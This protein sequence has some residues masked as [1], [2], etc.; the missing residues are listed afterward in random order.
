MN[1]DDHDEGMHTEGDRYMISD[2]ALDALAE[3]A[4]AWERWERTAQ[5][6]ERGALDDPGAWDAA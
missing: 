1:H 5:W 3:A 2:R 4:M 6:W